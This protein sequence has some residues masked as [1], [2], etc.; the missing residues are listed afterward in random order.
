MHLFCVNDDLPR[1]MA[2]NASI[3]S[4]KVVRGQE[5]SWKQ[6]CFFTLCLPE[7]QGGYNYF[8]RNAEGETKKLTSVKLSPVGDENCRSFFTAVD[9]QDFVQLPSLLHPRG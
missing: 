6:P 7:R 8:T 3:V 5:Q 1:G 4:E 2:S 9:Y